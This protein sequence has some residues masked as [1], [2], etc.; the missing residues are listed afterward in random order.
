MKMLSVR[1]D[2]ALGSLN[3]E[4]AASPWQG[5]G[6]WAVRSLPTQALP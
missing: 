3:W 5:L 2:G 6:L 1:L 4:V